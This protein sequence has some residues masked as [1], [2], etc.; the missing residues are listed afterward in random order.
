MKKTKEQKISAAKRKSIV[1]AIALSVVLLLSGTL[2]LFTSRSSSD[3][4]AQSGTVVL[5][6]VGLNLTNS[7]NINPG[8]M[9][10][11]NSGDEYSEGTPHEFSYTV[12]G[13]GSKSIRT[14]QTILLSVDKAGESEDSLDASV[15]KLFEHG[16]ENEL[17]AEEIIDEET[18]IVLQG[19]YYILSDDTEIKDLSE[20]DELRKNDETLFVKTVKYIFMGN[21]YDGLGKDITKGGN[22]EKE[23]PDNLLSIVPNVKLVQEDANGDIKEDFVYDFGILPFL[24]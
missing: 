12:Y 2:A 16:T 7:T 1:V 5:E 8:D 15:L 3:F 23:D 14:R 22:A 24:F 13:T 20:L 17:F 9:D 6:V 11:A 18:G 19:R 4:K 21:I 10:P